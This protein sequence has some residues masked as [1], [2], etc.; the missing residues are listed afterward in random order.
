[1]HEP[2]ARTSEHIELEYEKA[3]AEPADTIISYE[4]YLAVVGLLELAKQ[5]NAK[6]QDL[7]GSLAKIVGEGSDS[8]YYGHVSDAIYCEYSAQEL[9]DRLQIMVIPQGYK[10]YS[11]G[12]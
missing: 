3:T 7:E 9:L 1:M 5:Y 4:Q 12:D 2:I 6:L 8:N 10:L 11:H